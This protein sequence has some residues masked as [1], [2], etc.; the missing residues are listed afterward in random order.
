MHCY[1]AEGAA[2]LAVRP[3]RGR[4]AQADAAELETALRQAP[5]V[6]GLTQTRWTLRALAQVVPSLQ[7]FTDAGV[8]QVLHRLGYRYKRGQPRLTSPDPAYAEKRGAWSRSSG[9]PRRSLA[10]S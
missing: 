2:G 6:Y 1:Q 9:K 10:R 5:R 8:R 7:G 3:G 4:P